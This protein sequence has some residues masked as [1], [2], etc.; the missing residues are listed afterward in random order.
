MD[1][2]KVTIDGRV[3]EV[4][5]GITVLEAAKRNG[6]NIP[7][8][9]HMDLKP[10]NFVNKPASCRVCVVEIEKRRNLAPACAT[11]VMDGMVIKTTSARV[12][13]ARKTIVELLLSDHP[14]DCLQCAKSGDCEL[15]SLATRLGI[16]E[17]PFK[18]MQKHC[19]KNWL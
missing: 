3:Y 15:Q 1:M 14:N 7:T 18:G 17:I 4:E 5:K 13:N 19:L 8:L 2:I 16:R 6:I 10:I 11:E 9:C 12:L